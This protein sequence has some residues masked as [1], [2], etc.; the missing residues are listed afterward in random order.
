MQLV[1]MDADVQIATFDE[2]VR[3]GHVDEGE[4]ARR[5]VEGVAEQV[6]RKLVRA[7]NTLGVAA[8]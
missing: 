1:D 3:K 7:F 5:A 2:G 4:A 8:E 6:A